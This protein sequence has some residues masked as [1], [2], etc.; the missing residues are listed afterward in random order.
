MPARKLGVFVASLAICGL[1]GVAPAFAQYGGPAGG[2]MMPGMSPGGGMR[3][4]QGAGGDDK[5]EGP[6][7][8]AP[9]KDKDDD[10]NAPLAPLSE[11]ARRRTQ[12]LELDGYY[13]MRADWFRKLHLG[14]GYMEQGNQIV[15]TPP[16]P[17]PLDCGKGADC[18]Q[19]NLGSANMR[20]R[21]E[22]TINVSDQVRVLAQID[23]LDNTIAGSTPDSL[24]RTDRLEARN[25]ISPDA[26]LSNSQDPPEIGQNGYVSSV[27]AKRAW[28]EVDTEFGTL[29]FGRMPWHFGRGMMFNAGRCLDC[30]GGT[31]VDRLMVMSKLWGHDVSVSWD[32]G[33]Q[34]LTA[35]ATNL[36]T[37]DRGNIPLDLS[38]RDDTLQLMASITK[39]QTDE[40]FR[41]EAGRG[42]V[43]LNYGVQA[44]YR[45][46]DKASRNPAGGTPSVPLADGAF[47]PTQLANGTST[48]FVHVG[49]MAIIPSVWFKLG[50]KALTLEFESNAVLGRIEDAG[51]L[52]ADSLN[53]KLNLR[54]LGWVFASDLSLFK[55]ALFLGLETGGATGDKAEPQIGG[56]M[57]NP[58]TYLNYRWRSVQQQ[59]GDRSI[60]DFRFSPEYHVDQILFRRILGTVTNAIYLKPQLAYW[61]NLAEQKQLGINGAVIYSM[62]ASS[63]GTPGNS[64]NLGL[65]TNLGLTYRNPADGFYAGLTWAV[66]FPMAGLDRPSSSDTMQPWPVKQDASTAQVLRAFFGIQF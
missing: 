17:R 54:Q 28:G 21:L 60:T 14:Q 40:Q 24:V 37:I 44:V 30:D 55:N 66:L 3:P 35:N 10:E 32:Y 33:S 29:K 64:R 49:A 41:S 58:N 36:G 57:E 34:G 50:W 22:P 2:G 23:V 6:A 4:P 8:A 15:A 38:Q 61:L 63:Q 51:S 5:E 9:D 26:V 46:T 18:G 12:V 62:A 43:A 53:K 11:A 1:L 48:N 39:L 20:L 52:T 42:E 56:N 25:G 45:S 19:K 27:R 13:R 7:E 59:P 31:N 16:F 65:E 47:T